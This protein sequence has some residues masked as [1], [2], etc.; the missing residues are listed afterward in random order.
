MRSK[1]FFKRIFVVMIFL[2][3]ITFIQFSKIPFAT[4]DDKY[5][6]YGVIPGKLYQYV[7]VDTANLSRGYGLLATTI[8]T[9]VLVEVTAAE[10]DTLVQVYR[11]YSANDVSLVSEVSL[12]TM[13]K[14]YVLFPNASMFKVVT[15]K[16]ASVMLLSYQRI[17][18]PG[19][20]AS[21]PV[22]TTFHAATD[23][24]YVG[25]KFVFMASWNAQSNSWQSYMIF[26]L[27][28][29]DVT[30]TDEDG[31]Q[32]T[33]PL[34]VNEFKSISL[35]TFVSYKVESTGSI[36]V[37]SKGRQARGDP[38]RY[39]FVP[40][41]EGGYVGKFFYASSTTDWDAK[42][43]YG[44]R[45]SAARDAEVTIW[46][47]GTKEKLTTFTVKGGEGVGVMPKADAILVQSTSPVTLAYVH[48]GT[49][50][51]T[52]YPGRAYGAGLAYI[53]IKQN[54]KTLFFLPTNST[55]EA[56]IFV[57]EQAIV[58]LDDSPVTVE[59][60]SYHLLTTTPGTHS[61]VS[62]KN[63]IVEVIH[64][65]LNPPYQGLNFEGVEIPCV[66]TI[67]I[68]PTVTLTP[69]GESF[70]MMYII[71]GVGVAAVAVAVGLV[72]FVMKRRNK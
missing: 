35:T 54:E 20:N 59:A 23:G 19:Q 22:P 48:N 31:H 6:Y 44:F 27:E 60:G 24:A 12:D 47:L 15:N 1:K 58:T 14:H 29:A 18:S 66:E 41:A 40:S 65:P 52:I 36:M 25:K 39:Y 28:K 45:I 4:S 53:G 70:P 13:Q 3:L 55:D 11:V 62:N 5:T 8:R 46:N 7:D 21:G 43:D 30:V 57:N 51:R 17:P 56:Y 71:I 64:W 72:F 49:L 38:R 69:L 68:V 67:G 63:V 34:K 10:A 61:I 9:S 50:L 32:E 33:F 42:E 16:Y 2:A 37:E 26:A